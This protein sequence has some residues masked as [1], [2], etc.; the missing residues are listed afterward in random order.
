M[1]AAPGQE[2]STPWA[3]EAAAQL[4]PSQ[5]HWD[6]DELGDAGSLALDETPS[7]KVGLDFQG[8]LSGIPLL[9]AGPEHA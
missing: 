8:C 4:R 7:G 5:P 6:A 2:R 1:G 3:Q 9:A